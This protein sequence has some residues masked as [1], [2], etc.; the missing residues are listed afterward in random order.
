MA[1]LSQTSSAALINLLEQ[2]WRDPDV[3]VELTALST[4]NCLSAPLAPQR[5]ELIAKAKK[6]FASNTNAEVALALALLK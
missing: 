2:G 5:P 1:G 4:V 6:I 3:Q